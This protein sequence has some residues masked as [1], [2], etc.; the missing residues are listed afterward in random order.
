MTTKSKFYT[1]LILTCVGLVTCVTVLLWASVAYNERALS[2][3]PTP[4]EAC[5]D[6]YGKKQ[7]R[8]IPARCAVIMFEQR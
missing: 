7:V 4:E 3:V 2:K 5:W 8:F 1:T 6:L